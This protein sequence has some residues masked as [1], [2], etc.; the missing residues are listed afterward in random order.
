MT[1]RIF[2]RDRRDHTLDNPATTPWESIPERPVKDRSV[3][4]PFSSERKRRRRIAA[5]ERGEH[6]AKPVKRCPLCRASDR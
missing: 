4:K 5:H 2:G 6:A 3:R 1:K